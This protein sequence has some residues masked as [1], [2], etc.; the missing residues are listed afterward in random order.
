MQTIRSFIAVE[1]PGPVQKAVGKLLRELSSPN[2]GIR[3]VPA[4]HLHLTL[5]FLG[6][7]DNTEVPAVC[8]TIRRACVGVSPF[9]LQVHGTGGFPSSQRARVLFAG[10]EDPSGQLRE[11][12]ANLERELS[13]LGFKPESRDYTP[14]LTLGRV[15]RGSRSAGDPVMTHLDEHRET[16]F[17]GF[18][19][20]RVLLMAS[21]LDNAGP[22]YQKMDSVGLSP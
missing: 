20:A 22:T 4:D 15:R 8:Q 13:E 1:L 11:L 21:F 10:L 18:T 16:H 3:W 7:V 12:V 9:D 5:K 2:D 19:V 14:H 17:G 6:D